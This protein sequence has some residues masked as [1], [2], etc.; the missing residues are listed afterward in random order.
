LAAHD[1]AILP[2]LHFYQHAIHHGIAV[3]FITGRDHSLYDGTIKNLRA[4]GYKQ[5]S[6]ISFRQDKTSIIPFKT[7][8]RLKIEQKG[9]TILASIGDQYSDLLGG[10]ALRVFKLPNP[11]YY[12]P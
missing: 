4:A 11:F 8:E 5:W 9:Y 3:F 12:L 2:V 7:S 10:H 1:P 6:G